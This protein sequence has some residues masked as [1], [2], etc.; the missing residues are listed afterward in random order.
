[1]ANAY[2]SHNIS[3]VEQGL[4]KR[5]A[6]LKDQQF[7]L[8]RSQEMGKAQLD[9]YTFVQKLLEGALKEEPSQRTINVN[10]IK[11][12]LGN[13]EAALLFA[14]LDLSSDPQLKAVAVDGGRLV[15][16][17]FRIFL[18]LGRH[19]GSRPQDSKPVIAAL[20]N[21]GFQIKGQDNQADE[22]GPGVDYFFDSDKAAAVRAAATLND[23][24]GS[25]PKPFVAR[26]QSAKNAEGALG[27]WF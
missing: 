13:D 16:T 9:R 15:N 20:T 18:H 24:I 3:A 22:F 14:G 27:V 23:L 19:D 10:L 25:S 17:Q 4:K 1:V 7:L 12:A 21:S 2:W 6:D 5:E 8:L 26:R 11:L